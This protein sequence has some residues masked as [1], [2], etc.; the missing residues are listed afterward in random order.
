[1]RIQRLQATV[2]EAPRSHSQATALST[3]GQV[4]PPQCSL[5]PPSARSAQ[6]GTGQQTTA[7]GHRGL[8]PTDS[9]R[10]GS[11]GPASTQPAITIC[12]QLCGSVS[13]QASA[14]HRRRLSGRRTLS[15]RPPSRISHHH[16][17]AASGSA[18]PE[19]WPAGHDPPI[20]PAREKEVSNFFSRSRRMF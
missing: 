8:L 1:M 7:R 5:V 3:T 20:V 16:S 2:S 11:V 13:S 10:Q 12:R 9:T 14:E 15:E 19:R 17:R 4:Q 6:G 18:G